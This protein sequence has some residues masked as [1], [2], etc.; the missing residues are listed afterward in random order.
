MQIV[1]NSC[2][3]FY[4]NNNNFSSKNKHE[5]EQNCN[6]L[7]ALN[8]SRWLFGRVARILLQ[9]TSWIYTIILHLSTF[10]RGTNETASAILWMAAL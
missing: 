1:K 10:Q 8:I 5:I 6:A 3:E 4:K 2:S 7:S 9:R